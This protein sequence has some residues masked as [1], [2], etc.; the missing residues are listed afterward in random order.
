MKSYF[1]KKMEHG[2]KILLETSRIPSVGC[3]IILQKK[4]FF[5][6]PLTFWSTREILLYF[7]RLFGVGKR[8]KNGRSYTPGKGKVISKHYSPPFA[9]RVG[10][11]HKNSFFIPKRFPLRPPRVQAAQF[12]KWKKERGIEVVR[13]KGGDVCRPR[14][15]KKS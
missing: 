14:R 4:Y 2:K 8:G 1:A 11:V 12:S 5:Y 13:E 3:Y 6:S 15:G 7:F 9:S 10:Q